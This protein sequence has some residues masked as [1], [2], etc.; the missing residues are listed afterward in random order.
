VGAHLSPNDV[1]E[2]L[3]ECQKPFHL[4][5]V[6]RTEIDAEEQEFRLEPLS[7]F[8]VGDAAQLD[9]LPVFTPAATL[10]LC[11]QVEEQKIAKFIAERE[12]IHFRQL[13]REPLPFGRPDDEDPQG[14]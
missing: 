14:L 11:R 13:L 8:Q 7:K 9:P 5:N 3:E 10:D 2:A 4:W 1:G 12:R 6:E